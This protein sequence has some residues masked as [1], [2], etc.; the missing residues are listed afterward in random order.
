MERCRN[1]GQKTLATLDWAC[2]WCG[3][4]LKTG[5]RLDKTYSELLSERQAIRK[6]ESDENATEPYFSAEK[7]VD[8]SVNEVPLEEVSETEEILVT[9]DEEMYLNRAAGSD[10]EIPMENDFNREQ[11][12]QLPTAAIREDESAET[13]YERADYSE[14]SADIQPPA[15][16][17]SPIEEAVEEGLGP[18]TGNE[19][20][21]EPV[22]AIDITVEELLE[23]YQ[24][25]DS[26]ADAKYNNQIL[27]LTGLVAMINLRE[28]RDIQY[29]NLTGQ[30]QNLFRSIKCM[31]SSGNAFQ[32]RSLEWGQ[33]VV[34]K[35]RFKGSLTAMSLVDCSV[36]L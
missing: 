3:Q 16:E 10:D 22:F 2:P 35:G 13:G 36:I 11:V 28:N 15:Q 23:A 32:L 31:F 33:P 17:P 6:L 14:P 20:E 26:A 34:V 5:N 1:C 27:A 9:E 12:I 25:D 24:Q 8:L 30:D 29:V 7:A 19:S 18:E 4:P 21:P